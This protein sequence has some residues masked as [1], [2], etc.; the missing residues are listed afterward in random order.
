MVKFTEMD[1]QI[2]LQMQLEEN[3][4]PIVLINK[5]NVASEDVDQFIQAWTTDCGYITKQSG[6]ISTQLHRGIGNSCTFINYAIWESAEDFKRAFT[7]P[8]FQANLKFY[9][10]SMETAP[11]L[12]QKLAVPGVCVGC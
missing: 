5:F 12:F 3:T 11:H 1:Q 4:G 2:T 9:P 8:T 7:S 10:S 6:F